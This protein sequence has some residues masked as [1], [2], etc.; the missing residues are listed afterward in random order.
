MVTSDRSV[1]QSILC[2]LMVKKSISFKKINVGTG[3]VIYV[4]IAEK[5]HM[6]TSFD[7]HGSRLVLLLRPKTVFTRDDNM[8]YISIKITRVEQFYHI[9]FI[10]IP[11][12]IIK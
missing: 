8:L 6:S 9:I 7:A 5:I 10:K 12:N 2:T 1:Q 4:L 11:H 3:E